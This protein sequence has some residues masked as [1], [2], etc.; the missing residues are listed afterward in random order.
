M[1]TMAAP[2]KKI[3][4][5]RKSR[6]KP[7]HEETNYRPP[8]NMPDV[9]Q[10][11]TRKIK[12]HPPRILSTKEELHPEPEAEPTNGTFKFYCYRCG[13][14][15]EAHTDWSGMNVECTT[16]HSKIQIPPPP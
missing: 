10:L 4:I 2:K 15:L 8:P 13:Q 9:P 7:E 11:R 16:C 6:T 5:K 3:V 12:P 14:K 1:N